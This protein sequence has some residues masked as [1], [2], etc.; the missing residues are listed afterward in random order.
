M[1]VERAAATG[2]VGQAAAMV[3]A[4]VEALVAKAVMEGTAAEA[5]TEPSHPRRAGCG[6]CIQPSMSSLGMC[7]RCSHAEHGRRAADLCSPARQSVSEG[8]SG[9]QMSCPRLSLGRYLCSDRR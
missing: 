6:Q 8:Q 2:E 3:E 1:A 7:H 5:R 4:K 9:C